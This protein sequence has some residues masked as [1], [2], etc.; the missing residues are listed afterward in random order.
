MNILF[1]PS[2]QASGIARAPSPRYDPPAQVCISS[3]WALPV[4][5][6]KGLCSD[7]CQHDH[8]MLVLRLGATS[9]LAPLCAK[10]GAATNARNTAR[11]NKPATLRI[12]FIGYSSSRPS[13][14]GHKLD[15]GTLGPISG[16]A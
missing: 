12:H 9:S 13:V 3:E 11:T 14:T 6:R 16:G 4:M 5:D 10:T 8:C 15:S 2:G 1:F 7:R